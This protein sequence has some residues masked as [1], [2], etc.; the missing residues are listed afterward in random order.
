MTLGQI[1]NR[2]DH[3]LN[4]D[5]IHA[6]SFPASF[7]SIQG[8]RSVAGTVIALGDY[9]PCVRAEQPGQILVGGSKQP[10]GGNPEQ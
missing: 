1:P 2:A 10:D 5:F 3:I 4:L 6:A 7:G 8:E 9:L